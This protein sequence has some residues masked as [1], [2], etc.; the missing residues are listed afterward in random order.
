MLNEIGSEFWE[1]SNKNSNKI[2]EIAKNKRFLL[3][4]RTA[5]DFLIKDIKLRGSLNTVY[6]P[7]YCCAT[8]IQPFLN[9][10]VKVLF[11]NVSESESGGFDF[12]IVYNTNCDAVFLIQY[13]GYRDKQI[14]NMAKKFK[15]KGII[16][17]EDITHSIFIEQKSNEYNDYIFASLRKWTALYTG[18]LAIKVT[19]NFVINTPLQ[20]NKVYY[21]LRK[22][23]I[24]LK[25]EYIENKKDNKCEF[26]KLFDQAENK[27]EKDY[28]NY[29]MD[30]NSLN[31]LKYLD[32]IKLKQKRRKN[33]E[34]ILAGISK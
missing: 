20:T 13:F 27:L 25:Y 4:G 6:L 32:I 12:E 16:V 14:E 1:I 5:L 15:S 3:S 31:S 23:A 30:G 8:M 33:A 24:E 17:I 29:L 18:G 26:L 34:M 10:G 7:S 2:F 19:D 11:Y 9:N 22:D 21:Q 28:C